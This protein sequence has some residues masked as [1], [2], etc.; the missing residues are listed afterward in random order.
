MTALLKSRNFSLGTHQYL[1]FYYENGSR[2]ARPCRRIFADIQSC[3]IE[4]KTGTRVLRYLMLDLDAKRASG[5]WKDDDDKLDIHKIKDYLAQ[6]YPDILDGIEYATRSYGGKGIHLIFG[7]SAFPLNFDTHKMQNLTRYTQRLLIKI[8]DELEMGADMG[9]AGLGRYFS[10]FHKK[11]NVLYHNQI[12][13]AR[14]DTQHKYNNDNKI[15]FLTKLYG[16]AKQ[17]ADS[18]NITRIYRI[19]S[20][21]AVE[22][23]FANLYLYLMGQRKVDS[24]KTLNKNLVMEVNKKF[25]KLKPY[26]SVTLTYDQLNH[27]CGLNKTSIKRNKTFENEFF[28]KLF[29]IDIL[30]RNTISI[31]ANKHTKKETEKILYRCKDVLYY[32][33]KRGKC[34]PELILPEEVEEG[35]RNLATWSWALHYKLAGYDESIACDEIISRIYDKET[36]TKQIECV[37]RSMYA[38]QRHL[39]GADP[40]AL[41]EFLEPEDCTFLLHSEYRRESSIVPRI[42]DISEC[43][44]INIQKTKKKTKAEKEDIKNFNI[45]KKSAQKICKNITTGAMK[46]FLVFCNDLKI[47]ENSKEQIHFEPATYV[48]QDGFVYFDGKHYSLGLQYYNNLNI[49]VYGYKDKVYFYEGENLIETH[50]KLYHKYKKYSVKENHK[51]SWDVIEELNSIHLYEAKRVGQHCYNFLAAYLVNSEGFSD[52]KFLYCFKELQGNS[53]ATNITHKLNLACKIALERNAF[54]L[55]VL[56]KILNALKKRDF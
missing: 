55:R 43:L 33:L 36:D 52:Q 42:A 50:D 32:G 23:V 40:E 44:N 11:E 24:Y 19:H 22:K 20:S 12:L 15:P 13:K 56:N 17:Y 39:F 6:N 4:N 5:R 47:P 30:D 14:I 26:E 29:N 8:F 38:H 7:F 45:K 1:E 27:L 9:A 28:L 16:A 21:V 35:N 25:N 18:L 34:T 37:V 53:R 41:P 10:T 2:L 54:S 49:K 51:L 3:V 46:T 31:S 48:R